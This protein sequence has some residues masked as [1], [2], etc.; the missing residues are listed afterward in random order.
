MQST[1]ITVF[2]TVGVILGILDWFTDIIY[3]A[4]T[5][6]ISDALQMG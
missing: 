3:I 1:G 6:F 5:D 2:M 4:A